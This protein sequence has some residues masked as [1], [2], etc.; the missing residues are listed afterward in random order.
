MIR[1]KGK[2]SD[3]APLQIKT[4][5][6]FLQ[7]PDWRTVVVSRDYQAD[8]CILGKHILVSRPFGHASLAALKQSIALNHK[9]IDHGIP[10]GRSY[11]QIEDYTNLRGAAHDARRLFIEDLKR[12]KNLLALIFCNTS[13]LFNLSIN[14]GKRIHAFGFD[15]HLSKG[16]H[17]AVRLAENILSEK[18]VDWKS[19]IEIQPPG[20]LPAIVHKN[21][22]SYQGQRFQIRFETIDGNII[23]TVSSGTFKKDDIGP[24]FERMKRVFDESALQNRPYYLVANLEA[25]KKIDFNARRRY[26]STLTQWHQKHPFKMFVFYNTGWTTRAAINIAKTTVPYAVRIADSFNA[27]MEWIAADRSNPG[28]EPAEASASHSSAADPNPQYAEELIRILSGINWDSQAP[29]TILRQVAPSHPFYSVVE[30]ISLI[31]LD[32]DQLL[33]ERRIFEKDLLE[34]RKKHKEILDGIEEG[35]YE[36]DL[37]GTITF[38]NPG[39]CRILGYSK[40]ELME[41]NYRKLADKEQARKIYQTFNQAY[42]TRRPAKAFDW[43][44]I[45]GDNSTSFIDT[46]VALIEDENGNP[47]GF[48]GI[49]R[50]ITER[51]AA[52]TERQK[53]EQQLRHAQKMEAIGTLAGGVAHDLNNILSGIVSYPELLLMKIPTDSPLKKPLETIKASGEKAAAIVSDLLTLA[54]KGLPELK[55]VNLNRIIRDYLSSPEYRSLMAHHPMVNI[56]TDLDDSLLNLNASAVHVFK[57]IINLVTNAAEAMPDGGMVHITTRNSYI[58]TPIHGYSGFKEGE[59]VKLQITDEGTGIPPEDRE[60]IF[61]PFY[62][63]K[64]AGR[65]GSGLGMTMVWGAV[66]DHGGYIDIQSAPKKGTVVTIHLPAVRTE[67]LQEAGAFALDRF[68][69]RGETILV[70]DDLKDQ[71]EIAE[72]ML[73]LLGYRVATAASGETAL[74]YLQQDPVDLVIL[75]MIMDPGMDGLDTYKAIKQIVPLQKTLLVTGFSS[76]KRIKQA[77]SLGAGA[78]LKKPFLFKEI[79]RTVREELER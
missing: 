3:N 69:G 78:C 5:L 20:H 61:E 12:R 7:R 15:I 63:K 24:M 71:R 9:V 21:E 51:I 76:S 41:M 23:H 45:R 38:A 54:R 11:V 59:Y 8:F 27:A 40:K 74:A 13:P 6:P 65:S 67:P 14:L 56:K 68:K 35:Y 17:E 50:D 47:A 52:E 19:P 58:D 10:K 49:V 57:I 75:D 77:Q 4:D 37:A 22:W 48:R 66:Q 70:V 55:T 31:K 53:L 18:G 26:V 46:S 39:L 29:E 72:Q 16:L 25:V 34:S 64:R 79:A 33:R 42:Q 43:K 44:L 30:A 62:T 73:T 1:R 36:T 28:P 32:I 60:R 2:P